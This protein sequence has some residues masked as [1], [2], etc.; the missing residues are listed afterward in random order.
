MPSNNFI[1]FK[2]QEN[3]DE[4]SLQEKTLVNGPSNF[5]KNITCIHYFFFIL[6]PTPS[7]IEERYSV[8][9]INPTP[10]YQSLAKQY[11]L[12]ATQPIANWFGVD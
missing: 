4:Y 12:G 1:R 11:D 3:K 2:N 9:T 10:G 7:S 5:F 8:E 6:L